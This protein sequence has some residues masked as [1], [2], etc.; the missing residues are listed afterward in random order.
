M[1]EEFEVKRFSLK[2]RERKVIL[3]TENGGER[4]CFIREMDGRNRDAFTS[5][6]S[7]RFIVNDKGVIVGMKSY[8]GQYAL[9]LSLCMFDEEDK[10]LDIKEIQ[11]F[12][13]SVQQE[14]HDIAQKLNWINL[15]GEEKAKNA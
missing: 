6:N 9:L 8:D 14:L 1:F 15:D 5:R 13:S 2:R 12:P 4:V 10:L 11:T 3:E 7:A